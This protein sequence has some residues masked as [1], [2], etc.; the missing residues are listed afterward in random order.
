MHIMSAA[1]NDF[2]LPEWVGCVGG[3]G[4]QQASYA[5]GTDDI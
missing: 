1:A 2:M 4:K 5:G 3:R